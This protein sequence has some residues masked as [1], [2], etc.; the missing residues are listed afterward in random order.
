MAEQDETDYSIEVLQDIKEKGGKILLYIKWE[1][2]NIGENTWEPLE[3]LNEGTGIGLLRQLKEEIKKKIKAKHTMREG[4]IQLKTKLKKIKKAISLRKQ[5]YIDDG[6][7]FEDSDEATYEVNL[8]V[9]KES[10]RKLKKVGSKKRSKL[11]LLK[12]AI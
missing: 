9:E 12:M 6:H 3:H 5:S 2:F 1:G 10:T 7:D 8:D 11:E 4:T